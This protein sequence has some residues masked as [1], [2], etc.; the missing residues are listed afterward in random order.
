M[1]DTIGSLP[2]VICDLQCDQPS[3]AACH[4]RFLMILY[5]LFLVFVRFDVLQ[6]VI[7]WTLQNM[8]SLLA[9]E[10]S[11]AKLAKRIPTTK[12]FF[13]FFNVHS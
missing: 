13:S 7:R 8:L 3:F 4:P 9:H 11:D 2:C 10:L 1:V 6:S 12:P 5:C